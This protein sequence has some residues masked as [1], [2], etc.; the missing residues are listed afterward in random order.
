M[1]GQGHICGIGGGSWHSSNNETWQR[2]AGGLAV[3]P[4]SGRC[5][6]VGVTAH[7]LGHTFSLEHDFR[8][9][10]NLMAYGSQSRLSEYT[11]DWLSVH[12]YFNTTSK[13]VGQAT[14][15]AMRS[16]RLPR[17]QF[18]LTDSDGLH[19]AQ[20]LI[21][22]TAADPV[23][24]L[25]LHDC[26]LLGGKTSS[27]VAFNVSGGVAGNSEVTL[28]VIDVRGNISK[29]TFSV[30]TDSVVAV[31]D[32]RTGTDV[33]TVSLS[34]ASVSPAGVGE[35][36]VLNLMISGG[37]DVVGYQATVD[38]DTASLRYVSS[39]NA[40]YLAGAF[41]IPTVVKNNRVTLA[42]TALQGSSEGDG[43]LATLTFKV[44][45]AHSGMP[46]VSDA[47]LTDSN[48]DFLA[49]RIENSSVSEP[50]SLAGDVNGD[51]VLSV[52]DLSWAATRLGQRGEN[53]ADMNGDG[54]VD[55]A[56]LLLIATAIDQGNAAPSLHS[57]S[58]AEMFTAAEVR[59]WLWLARQQG[60][61]D[62]MYQRGFLLLEQ[63]L[64]ILTPKETALLSNYPN[65]F[66]PE[67]WIP[68]HLSEPAEVRIAIY[69]ADGRLV[70]TLGLGHQ[71]AGIYES[72]SCAAYWDGRNALG[73]PVA[74]SVYFY[75]LTAGDF[76]A[77]RKMLIRK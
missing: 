38:F 50:V 48:A 73:E 12:P 39:A 37:V 62:P 22:T 43:T 41:V 64:V 72:R 29:Q 6:T 57:D 31:S 61:T 66:N 74:S 18:H 3:I 47:K 70:R 17:L 20:L 25:K 46:S 34:P 75:T 4:A 77:T 10:A 63:F 67:T 32:V 11:A 55:A 54:V 28:Q 58:V 27:T 68:Y 44:L 26:Q 59:R 33:A 5:F 36:F 2:N 16:N 13:G 56:D 42:A 24:G 71:A 14:M 15:L 49:V 8:D 1:G 45:T 19:Q 76:A 23:G 21:P 51:G 53:T 30:K 35:H 7:E 9:D 40:E 65:P 60:L 52:E 69:A